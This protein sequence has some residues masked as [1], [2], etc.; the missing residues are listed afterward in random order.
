MKHHRSKVTKTTI[1]KFKNQQNMLG[2]LFYW[3]W[4]TTL[5]SQV[6]SEKEIKHKSISIE[7]NFKDKCYHKWTRAYNQIYFF[8]FVI[9]HKMI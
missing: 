7:L 8:N 5:L 4:H 6:K 9:I 1:A 3:P 2:P